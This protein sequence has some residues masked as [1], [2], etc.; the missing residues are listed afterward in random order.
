MHSKT[1]NTYETIQRI[2]N[3]KLWDNKKTH[4]QIGNNSIK[5]QFRE[6]EDNKLCDSALLLMSMKK[7]PIVVF[8]S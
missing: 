6:S 3:D 7:K 1:G 5:E 8:L 2:K 4:L